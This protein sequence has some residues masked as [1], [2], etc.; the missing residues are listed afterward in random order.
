[1]L[2]AIQRRCCTQGRQCCCRSHKNQAYHSGQS[3]EC[4][5]L[6]TLSYAILVVRRLVSNRLD[7]SHYV[8]GIHNLWSGFKLGIC[9]ESP[10]TVPGADTAKVS[11]SLCML[12]KSVLF[13]YLC[14]GCSFTFST[15]A[16]ATAWSRLGMFTFHAL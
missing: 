15:T 7:C 5:P 2:F 8:S 14:S 11:R 16:I 4:E 6:N 13:S 3:S 12:S 1:M 9:N 10:A